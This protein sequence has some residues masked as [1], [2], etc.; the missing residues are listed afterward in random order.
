MSTFHNGWDEY[1]QTDEL[2]LYFIKICI[3]AKVHFLKKKKCILSPY[4]CIFGFPPL[5]VTV[6]KVQAKATAFVSLMAPEQGNQT[7]FHVLTSR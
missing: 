2:Y 1:K 3:D 5:E 4:V 6:C 7:N